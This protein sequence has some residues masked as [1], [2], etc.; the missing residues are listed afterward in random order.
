MAQKRE[1]LEAEREAFRKAKDEYDA[2]VNEEFKLRVAMERSIRQLQLEQ[3]HKVDRSNQDP[4]DPF[5]LDP[6]ADQPFHDPDA[7]ADDLVGLSSELWGFREETICSPC[8]TKFLSLQPR[9]SATT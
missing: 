3:E 5:D 6:P 7:D 1:A 4:A 2:K 9:W 8:L